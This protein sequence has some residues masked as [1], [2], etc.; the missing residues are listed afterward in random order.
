MSADAAPTPKARRSQF[1]E[2]LH[3]LLES[4]SD[5]DSLRWV[6]DGTAFEVTSNE[7]KARAALSPKFDFRSLSSF[8]RQLSYYNF[9][10]LSDRRRSSERKNSSNGFIMFNHPSGAFIRGDSSQLQAIVRKARTR[11]EKTRRN[12]AVSTGS[13]E[14]VPEQSWSSGEYQP[15]DHGGAGPSFSSANPFT[16]T[17]VPPGQP[18][19]YQPPVLPTDYHAQWKSYTSPTW[20]HAHVPPPP[21]AESC[22]PQRYGFA[23]APPL[24]SPGALPPVQYERLVPE[25]Q[26]QALRRSSLSDFK[27]G[28]S[29][30]T[31]MTELHPESSSTSYGHTP[32]P[33]GDPHASPY[34]TPN[35]A[36]QAGP[37]RSFEHSSSGAAGQAPEQQ[38][39]Q[40]RA[41]GLPM[42]NPRGSISAEGAA[43]SSS[44][45]SYTPYP[46]PKLQPPSLPSL[47][48]HF[49]HPHPQ[50]PAEVL[51]SPTYSTDDENP[52]PPPS[53]SHLYAPPSHLDSRPSLPHLAP[54]TFSYSYN[55]PHPPQQPVHQQQQQ[56]HF[57]PYSSSSSSHSLPHEHAHPPPPPGN[58]LPP[59]FTTSALVSKAGGMGHS[60]SPLSAVA[61]SAGAVGNHPPPPLSLHLDA[62][63][64]G[65][66]HPAPVKPGTP[67]VLQNQGMGWTQ[68]GGAEDQ[69]DRQRT[70]TFDRA[71]EA[72]SGTVP[73]GELG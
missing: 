6:P 32:S 9:K 28:I 3:D 57:D 67:G 43:S 29:P 62:G 47:A 35:Y 54:P 37:A 24:P 70:T 34:P 39:Q 46:A 58:Y 52:P 44:N 49:Y 2:K 27:V 33:F 21:P 31:K 19:Q 16:F 14:D 56:S 45:L 1:I 63:A 5:P 64:G 48:P 7:L 20:Q 36:S 66:H 61:N 17:A 13:A 42:V 73:K 12:S 53:S 55:L 4:P 18:M 51:P 71:W 25:S 23:G 59:P 22:D 41:T 65:L 10:R 69:G 60:P 38:Q 40:Y 8:I 11:P 15:Y 26:H 50:H 30:R 68:G 72:L